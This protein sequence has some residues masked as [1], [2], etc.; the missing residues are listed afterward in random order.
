MSLQPVKYHKAAK[1][2]GLS[3]SIGHWPWP[4]R[5]TA[6]AGLVGEKRRK[7]GL[8]GPGNRVARQQAPNPFPA[9][10]TLVAQVT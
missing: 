2:V 7:P 1:L 6:G 8:A 4:S 5:N 3:K 9:W 10:E